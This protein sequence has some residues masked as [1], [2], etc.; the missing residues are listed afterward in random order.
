MKKIQNLKDNRYNVKD[1]PD[2]ERPYEKCEMYG[3]S[4]LSDAELLAA[5]IRCGSKKERS[6]ELASRVLNLCEGRGVVGLYHADFQS[7]MKLHGIGRVKAVQILCVAELAKRMAK[8]ASAR[9]IGFNCAEEIAAYYMEDMRHLEQEETVAVFLDSKMNLIGEKT[10]FRGSVGI[11]LFEPREILI[12]ALRAGA[13]NLVM[14]HNHP[15]GDPTP[16]SADISSTLRLKQA[17]SLTGINLRDHIIIG[18]QRY[19]SMKES[20]VLLK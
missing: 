13:V 7:L 19:I 8:A 10:V 20:G 18:D 9:K 15:S 1:L 5:I 4:S 12:G 16:S 2:N 6:V 3:A 17:C 14:L 11:S